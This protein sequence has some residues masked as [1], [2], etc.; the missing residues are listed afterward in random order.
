MPWVLVASEHVRHSTPHLHTAHGQASHSQQVSSHIHD[1]KDARSPVVG[2]GDADISTCG[3][4]GAGAAA[5]ALPL[6]PLRSDFSFLWY[7]TSRW[8]W[9]QYAWSC[10]MKIAPW[11]GIWHS[12]QLMPGEAAGASS[13]DESDF[14]MGSGGRASS[15]PLTLLLLAVRMG[16][17]AGV[18]TGDA[19]P[20][21]ARD[22]GSGFFCK[23]GVST[24]G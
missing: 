19:A 18:C 15:A 4:S 6:P 16:G 13:D 20:A 7:A 10:S 5:A 22:G 9:Q 11:I 23:G 8:R 2:L 21:G 12:M 24:S 17:G 3:V 1:E 14:D